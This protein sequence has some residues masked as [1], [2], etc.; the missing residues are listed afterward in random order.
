MLSQQVKFTRGANPDFIRTLR[1]RVITYFEENN[2]S[3]HGNWKMVTKTVV[4]LSLLFGPW[5]VMVVGG[6]SSPWA[7]LGLYAIMAIGKSGVGFSVMHDACHGSYSRYP[8][9]NKVL[10]YTMNFLGGNARN[11]KIQHN[12]LHH[13]FT[14]VEGMDEDIAPP[15]WLLRFSPH[16]KRYWIHRMQHI[17][18]WVLYALE[19][20]MWCTTKDFISLAKYRREGLLKKEDG[21]F[22][23]LITK[24]FIWKLVYFGYILV[25]PILT[26]NVSWWV[27]ILGFVLMH[28]ITGLLIA[29][30]FQAAHVMP[31]MEYPLPDD[32]GNLENNWAVHQILTTTNFAPK[33]HVFGWFIG[34]LNFQIE[35][36]L[37]PNICHIHYKKISSIVRRTAEEY[38][39]PYHSK[40]YFVQALAD[41]ARMLKLLGRYDDVALATQRS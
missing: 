9:V 3:T 11:W 34:G 18:G 30:V 23:V 15:A 35:H 19:T 21:K 8:W 17:Y 16:A 25:I 38:G 2:I 36:H 33:S 7:V 13:S 41:H 39:I 10:S 1:K 5:V 14:N 12:I 6:I 40:K 4:M 26:T 20:L 32:D 28:L 29:L 37:F 22:G 24:T 27:V 31:D